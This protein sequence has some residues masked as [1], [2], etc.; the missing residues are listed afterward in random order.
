M[1]TVG[2]RTKA[3]RDG[4]DLLAERFGLAVAGF[5]GAAADAPAN[6]VRAAELTEL[7]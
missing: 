1:S 4:I 2:K 7:R 5:A 3:A 6:L